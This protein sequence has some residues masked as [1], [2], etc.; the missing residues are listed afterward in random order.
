M[1]SHNDD[2]LEF[3]HSVEVPIHIM[4]TTDALVRRYKYCVESPY[5]ESQAINSWEFISGPRTRKGAVIDRSLKL[6]LPSH[7][8]ESGR[9]KLVI[10]CNVSFCY[11]ECIVT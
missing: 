10:L 2:Y 7:N 9:K 6:Y 11:Y 5:T 1:S 3:R 8:L 4:R